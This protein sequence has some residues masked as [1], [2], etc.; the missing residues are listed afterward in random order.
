MWGRSYAL[1]SMTRIEVVRRAILVDL[2]PWQ[3]GAGIVLAIALPTL[4]HYALSSTAALMPYAAYCP[5]IL[6]AAVFLGWRAALATAL[7][8]TLVV[9]LLFLR[10]AL[11]RQVVTVAVFF[12]ATNLALIAV[13]DTLRRT[14]RQLDA[15]AQQQDIVVRE[16]YHR[17]Q[18]A[19][20]VVQALIRVS[21]SGTDAEQ[22]RQDLLGRVHALANAN[23]LLDARRHSAADDQ[24]DTAI[25]HLVRT[26][27]APFHKDTAFRI[28]GP[29][30]V[31]SPEAAYHLLLVLHELCTNALKHGALSNGLGHVTIEWT[32]AATLHWIEADGP[33]TSPPT[34][35]GLGTGMF[36]RQQH[37]TID[38]DFA[39][40]GLRCRLSP[41]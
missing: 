32:E 38:R 19:L 14:V 15:L 24:P 40:C 41:R 8:A 28:R 13:G 1:D 31:I 20:G 4:A 5:F 29:R 34:R 23:R 27:T 30:V 12:M 26:A 33:P 21:K 25:D 2:A 18:N 37:W 3:K 9:D 11:A 39:P 16:M 35:R 22:F 36:A 7:A 10:H 6:F 17:V